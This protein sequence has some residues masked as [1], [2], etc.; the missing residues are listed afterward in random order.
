MQRGP[1][2][3]S[4]KHLNLLY[5]QLPPSLARLVPPPSR[6][7]AKLVCA[8]NYSSTASA[9]IQKDLQARFFDI[10]CGPPSLTREGLIEIIA[11]VQPQFYYSFFIIHFLF[12]IPARVILEQDVFEKLFPSRSFA[13]LEDDTMGRAQCAKTSPR[14]ISGGRLN[15]KF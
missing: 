15:I 6:M 11:R 5:T 2:G 13:S 4:A 12:C 1:Y 3:S 7:E 10:R 9:D 8:T 14:R